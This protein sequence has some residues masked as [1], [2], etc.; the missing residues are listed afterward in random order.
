MSYK[1]CLTWCIGGLIIMFILVGLPIII[2]Y[3][4]VQPK[5]PTFTLD[6]AS[7]TKFNLTS[8]NHLTAFFDLVIRA[9]NPNHKMKLKYS[10]VRVNIFKNK[11]R[12][13]EDAL[14]KFSQRKRN[15]TLLRSEVV[16][17]DVKLKESPGS[18]IRFETESGYINFDVFMTANLNS[19]NLEVN[20]KHAIV[21][22]SAPTGNS[23]NKLN[24]NFRS[25]GCSVRVYN[26]DA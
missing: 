13:A 20:C 10:R 4:V 7:V 5:N 24:D 25:I 21:N 15:V 8:D 11:Q 18:N 3:A 23:N 9:N 26:N 22:I 17:L 6:H 2:Y 14:D 1:P 16:A 12:L 19:N